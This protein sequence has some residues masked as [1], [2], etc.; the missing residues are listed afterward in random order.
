MEEKQ[1][2]IDFLKR[3]GVYRKFVN[4]VINGENLVNVGTI[5]E[6]CEQAGHAK[7]WVTASFNWGS[8]P[9]GHKF[10]SDISD[11]WIDVY[12]GSLP[13]NDPPFEREEDL[14]EV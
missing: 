13:L 3:E 14:F 9:Q 10:W 12:N 1:L 4:N 8:S 7:D 11:K 5:S 6:L 2:F